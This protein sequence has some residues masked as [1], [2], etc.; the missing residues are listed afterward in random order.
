MRFGTSRYWLFQLIGWGSFALINTFFAF[1]FDR[2][3]SSFFERLGIF[4]LL[5]VIFSHIMRLIINRFGLLQ[6]SLNVQLLQF[7]V[8]TSVLAFVVSYVTVET[9][10]GVNLLKS[11][12]TELL[13]RSGVSYW[14]SKLL[15]ILSSAFSY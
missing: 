4:L 11:E 14:F 6:K 15:L 9:L 8:I 12:E 7:L 10:I 2:L 5:G 3:T 1:S 13:Q